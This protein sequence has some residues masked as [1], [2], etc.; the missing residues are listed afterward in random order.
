[1]SLITD[2][3]LINNLNNYCRY[4]IKLISQEEL[5]I[6]CNEPLKFSTKTPHELVSML[7]FRLLTVSY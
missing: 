5:L 4:C 3:N 2:S 1:M 7:F 6:S